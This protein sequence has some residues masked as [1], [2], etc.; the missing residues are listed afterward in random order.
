MLGRAIGLTGKRK[1]QIA[2]RRFKAGKK[3]ERKKTGKLKKGSNIEND[4]YI[5]GRR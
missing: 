5:R 4:N 1:E 3:G 2:R